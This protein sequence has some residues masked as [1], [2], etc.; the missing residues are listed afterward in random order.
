MPCTRA[1]AAAG[2]TSTL[3]SRQSR[4]HT[5]DGRVTGVAT[6]KG[7]FAAD[8]VISTVPTPFVA[9]LVPDLPETAKAAYSRIANIGV[10]C[11]VLKLKRSVTPHFWVNVI[12]KRLPIPALS[13]SRTCGR[14]AR[15][16]R[17][18]RA[19]LHAG[20]EPALAAPRRGLRRGGDGVHH[21][22][23]SRN[24]PPRSRRLACGAAEAR[25]A[26]LP[27]GFC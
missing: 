22:R 12:D 23:Q 18:L 20:D 19:L 11:V 16:D 24:R 9:S 15:R 7:E 13:S 2:G 27:A 21:D 10:V 25:S 4:S 6:G 1:I 17:G 5:R 8:S 14:P 26:R 3:A